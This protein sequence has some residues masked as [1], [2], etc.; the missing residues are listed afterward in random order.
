MNVHPS[1]RGTNWARPDRKKVEKA[2]KKRAKKGG[3]A[4]SPE[5]LRKDENYTPPRTPSPGKDGPHGGVGAGGHI[6]FMQDPNQNDRGMD[7]N[8]GI[9]PN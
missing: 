5:Y 7:P 4:G 1:H 3:R 6:N 8:D 9:P 2:K